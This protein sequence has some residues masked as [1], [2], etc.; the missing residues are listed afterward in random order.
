MRLALPCFTLLALT[1]AACGGD[2]GP[3]R[4]D[5][6]TACEVGPEIYSAARAKLIASSPACTRDDECVLITTDIRCS[7]YGVSDCGLVVQKAVS[8]DWDP[9]GICESIQ[10]SSQP[11]KLSCYTSASCAATRASCVANKC[12]ATLP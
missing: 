3:D 8:G 9:A 12:V 1:S 11:S 10:A 7:G 2:D 4:P 6:P 5:G